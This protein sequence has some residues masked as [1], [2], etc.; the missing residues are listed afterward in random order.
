MRCQ[1]EREG[2]EAW[3]AALALLELWDASDV[4]KS[5]H[6]VHAVAKIVDEA[7]ADGLEEA[8]K[9]SATLAGRIGGMPPAMSRERPLAKRAGVT[10]LGEDV[11]NT[12]GAA[13]S[14][15]SS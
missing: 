9:A 11:A 2:T 12:A 7:A 15:A 10:G 4:K 8:I 3:S 1:C 5:H 14:G 13:E 6:L